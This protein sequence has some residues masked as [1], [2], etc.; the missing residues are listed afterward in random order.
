MKYR[1]VI[2]LRACMGFLGLVGWYGAFM[3]M[4]VSIA[5]SMNGIMPVFCSFLSFLIL[6]ESMSKYE[7]LAMISG[8]IGVIV[9]NDPFNT[10]VDPNSTHH[11]YLQ[12]TGYIILSLIFGSGVTLCMRYM[13]DIHYTIS[14][15][16]FSIGCS[17][18][19]P[20][21]YSVVRTRSDT[22]TVYDWWTVTLLFTQ[23]FI[24]FISKNFDS[25]SYQMCNISVVSPV[26]YLAL[27]IMFIYDVCI[28]KETILP[29]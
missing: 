26:Q 18:W 17:T 7:I 9:I 21:L 23:S 27:V 12:G 15:F 4:P 1:N 25:R 8:F 13:K 6:K 2:V 19:S 16:W 3:Y 22:T 29:H 10:D 28:L 14:P 5:Q 20:I 24:V 11:N